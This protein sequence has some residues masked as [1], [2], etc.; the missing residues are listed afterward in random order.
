MRPFSI[1]SE[2]QELDESAFRFNELSQNALGTICKSFPPDQ[3]IKL[4]NMKL[5]RDIVPA[6]CKALAT[7]TI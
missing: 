4:G 5:L 7:I 2:T 6:T 3:S 1:R